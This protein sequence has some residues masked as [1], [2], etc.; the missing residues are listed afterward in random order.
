M[1]S[2]QFNDKIIE[3]LASHDA[4]EAVKAHAAVS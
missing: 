4:G 3:E 1:A 2:N